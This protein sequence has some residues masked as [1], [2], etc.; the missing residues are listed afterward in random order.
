[1]GRMLCFTVRKA[2]LLMMIHCCLD[3]GPPA[4]SAALLC[5]HRAEQVVC[6][7]RFTARGSQRDDAWRLR[8][9]GVGSFS[10]WEGRGGGS[11]F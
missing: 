2:Q 10:A 4:R 3:P 7:P 1:M 8:G 11:V 9:L 5:V 6:M